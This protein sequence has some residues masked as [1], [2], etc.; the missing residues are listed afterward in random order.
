MLELIT[1]GEF[2]LNF[3]YRLLRKT[4]AVLEWGIKEII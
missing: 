1:T 4:K 3:Y 2:L